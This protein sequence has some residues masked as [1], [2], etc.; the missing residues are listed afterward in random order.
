MSVALRV[1]KLNCMWGDL[2]VVHDVTFDLEED[3][4][5]AIFG[6]NGAGKT[7]LLKGIINDPALRRQVDSIELYGEDITDKPPEEIVRRG[8][9][10]IPQE[11]GLF[12]DMTVRNNLELPYF[13]LTD[14]D[15]DDFKHRVDKIIDIF[16]QM[17]A[18]LDR[19]VKVCSGGEKKMTMISKGL[20]ADPD[21]LLIDE[22]NAALSPNL[23]KD[24]MRALSEE[25]DMTVLVTL[26]LTS[27]SEKRLG[28]TSR[29]LMRTGEI[30]DMEEVSELER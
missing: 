17:E 7:T 18:F 15:R 14:G 11:G 4:R 19:K 26:P 24:V 28:A 6:L 8:L 13:K 27:E 21:I 2:Q 9:G 1:R 16:P 29:Y 20:I 3:Q 10:F 12:G 25:L 30:F 23:R 5:M 22:P